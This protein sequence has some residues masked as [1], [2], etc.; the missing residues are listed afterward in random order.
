[1]N[2]FE[3]KYLDPILCKSK[4]PEEK[5]RKQDAQGRCLIINKVYSIIRTVNMKV[6]EIIHDSPSVFNGRLVC[7]VFKEE[8]LK[9]C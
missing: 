4:T 5:K 8:R 1:M 7:D 6:K 9:G 2:E 3:Y